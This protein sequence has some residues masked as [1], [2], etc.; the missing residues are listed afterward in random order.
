MLGLIWELRYRL[1]GSKKDRWRAQAEPQ[2]ILGAGT[3]LVRLHV[4]KKR[5]GTEGQMRPF[6]LVRSCSSCLCE[7]FL[8]L[9][10][11]SPFQD[12]FRFLAFSTSPRA[13]AALDLA[14][15]K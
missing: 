15:Y 3:R 13:F 7:C 11:G 4:R 8:V 1:G 2:E 6:D 9:I 12:R 14:T 10:T 5:A